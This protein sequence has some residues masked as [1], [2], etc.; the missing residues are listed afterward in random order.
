MA[1]ERREEDEEE[2]SWETWTG[3]VSLPLAFIKTA[4]WHPRDPKPLD[5]PP[6]ACFTCSELSHFALFDSL[7]LSLSFI[8]FCPLS[9]E[10]DR[11]REGERWIEKGG[12]FWSPARFFFYWG[13]STTA[14]YHFFVSLSSWTFAPFSPFLSILYFSLLAFLCCSSQIPCRW[15]CAQPNV[16]LRKTI[17]L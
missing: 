12:V 3:V 17:V 6:D 8:L 2:M 14:E 9:W 7:R 11:G 4:N 13:S 15:W 10:G 1:Y 16:T 5:P